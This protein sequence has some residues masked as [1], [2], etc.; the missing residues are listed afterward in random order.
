MIS[1]RQRE[2]LMNA[3]RL[4]DYLPASFS[5]PFGMYFPKKS[6]YQKFM[7]S[8]RDA[9]TNF[10]PTNDALESQ[11]SSPLTSVEC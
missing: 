4:T 7:K 2:H 10:S 5:P 3:H 9:A 8:F 1:S 11:I 6:Q